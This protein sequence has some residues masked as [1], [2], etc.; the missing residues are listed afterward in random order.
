MTQDH[1]K[2]T[3]SKQTFSVTIG[4]AENDE[5]TYE[6]VVYRPGSP[7]GLVVTELFSP[8]E[9]CET[10]KQAALVALDYILECS[11]FAEMTE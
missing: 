7:G 8:D 10:K 4:P 9:P 11:H 1:F 5:D 2:V 6:A 3:I